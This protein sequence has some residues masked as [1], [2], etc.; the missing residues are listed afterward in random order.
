HQ[1]AFHASD[2]PNVLA[3]GTRGS[4]KS[5][6]IRFDAALRCLMFPNFRALIIRRTM[7]E[8]RRSH[9][10]YVDREMKLLG[11]VFLH[12]TFL[13]KFPNGSTVQYAHCESAADVMNF[14]SSEYGAIYFDELSTFTLQ[15][16]LQ[17][18]A[19]ARAPSAA[20]YKA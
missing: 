2:A 12:T 9:L 4:G 1:I 8:L 10:A 14:L 13:A 7:P 6:M 15:Q 5:V 18:S 16:F 3:L 20:P 17:I 19:A 11:G